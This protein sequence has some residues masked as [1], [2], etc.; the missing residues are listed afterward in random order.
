MR[1]STRLR[2]IAL[3]VNVERLLNDGFDHDHAHVAHV[4]HVDLDHDHVNHVDHVDRDHD[5]VDHDAFYY[6]HAHAISSYQPHLYRDRT[7][8]KVLW[9]TLSLTLSRASLVTLSKVSSVIH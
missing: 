6:G 4:D 1:S 3:C 7:R 9:R 8:T 5:H 2:L